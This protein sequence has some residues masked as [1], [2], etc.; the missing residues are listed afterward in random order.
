LARADPCN[1]A[2]SMERNQRINEAREICGVGRPYF[3]PFGESTKYRVASRY[4]S[5]CLSATT[6]ASRSSREVSNRTTLCSR[7][8][9]GST[10]YGSTNRRFTSGAAAD[11][12]GATRPGCRAV[13][14]DGHAESVARLRSG[15]LPSLP[16]S[17]PRS[18]SLRRR[19]S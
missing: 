19:K 2:G 11:L 3:T 15:T 5:R 17:R 6:R 4:T 10:G 8:H 9:T 12:R 13:D 7:K 18:L 16:R 14:G 1:F